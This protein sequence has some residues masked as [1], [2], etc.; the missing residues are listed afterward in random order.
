VTQILHQLASRS[1]LKLFEHKK[2]KLLPTL[3]AQALRKEF[4]RVCE[5]LEMIDQE[6]TCRTI[7]GDACFLTD[8]FS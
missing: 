3:E 7:C 4:D 1:N 2:G 8:C 6:Y 5:G